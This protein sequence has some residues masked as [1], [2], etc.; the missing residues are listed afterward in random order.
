MS[1]YNELRAEAKALGIQGYGKMKVAELEAAVAA[2][3]T[4]PPA[5]EGSVLAGPPPA[6]APP[7]AAA[8]TDGE[9]AAPPVIEHEAPEPPPPGRVRVVTAFRAIVDDEVEHFRPGDQ[10]EGA[11]AARLWAIAR[12]HVTPA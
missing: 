11:V 4:A 1:T 12:P 8:V 2:A 9:P 6:A 5:P 3:K 7:E 10:A